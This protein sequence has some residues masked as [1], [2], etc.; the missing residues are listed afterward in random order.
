MSDI[1]KEYGPIIDETRGFTWHSD[2][3]KCT[4]L[5]EPDVA[6]NIADKAGF[7]RVTSYINRLVSKHCSDNTEED[8][9]MA[10]LGSRMVKM[11]RTIEQ[12]TLL[13]EK[14]LTD[15]GQ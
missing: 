1:R 7:E 14:K 2:K 10:I 15:T 11:Q 9:Q 12:L 4:I 8:N 6:A 13:V 5:L 3:V